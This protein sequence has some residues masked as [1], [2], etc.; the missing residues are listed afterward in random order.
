M[1]ETLSAYV[2]FR[3]EVRH[4]EPY[5]KDVGLQEVHAEL[6]EDRH[7]LQEDEQY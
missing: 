3:Q 5:R 4:C 2:L 6:L 7:V 1:L